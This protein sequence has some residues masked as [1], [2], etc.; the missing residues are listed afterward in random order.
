M[1]TKLK[2]ELYARFF[3]LNKKRNSLDL[4]GFDPPLEHLK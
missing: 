3:L 1:I 2:N 4:R